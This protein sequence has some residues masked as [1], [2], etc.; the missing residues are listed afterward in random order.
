MAIVITKQPVSVTAT[1]GMPVKFTVEATGVESYQWQFRV[2]AGSRWNDSPAAGNKTNTLSIDATRVRSGYGYR[3]VLT[4]TGEVVNT[5]AATLTVIDGFSAV[6][7]KNN[8]EKI[9]VTKNLT[10][11]VSTKIFLKESTSIINPVFLVEVPLASVAD[12]NYITVP[13][14]GRSYFITDI[15]SI[16]NALVELTCH[17]DVLS[18]FAD[19]IKQNFGIIHRQEKNWNL[20]LN[21]G[22]LQ[23]YQNPIIST[24][25]F[26]NG[27]D[28]FNFVLLTAGYRGLGGV[29]YEGGTIDFDVDGGGAPN[30]NSKTTGGLVDYVTAQLGRPYWYGTFGYTASASLLA[31]RRASYPTYYPDPGVPDFTTQYGERVHDCVGLVKGYRWS[32]TPNSTPQYV[33]SEDFGVKEMFNCCSYVVAVTRETTSMQVGGVLFNKNMTHCGVYVG[34]GKII[35]ARN[36]LNGVIMTDVSDRVDETNDNKFSILGIPNWLTVTTTIA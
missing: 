5:D 32:D 6:I 36:H 24:V 11:L 19:E 9:H 27:F 17:V 13:T 23:V 30:T 8:S 1:L 10:D 7:Q 26:P 12:A 21:D 4:A 14:F 22:V 25:K 18:S 29:S 3:C 31:N 28:E 2:S 15:K 20:Y 33:A 34:G 16:T 35:E